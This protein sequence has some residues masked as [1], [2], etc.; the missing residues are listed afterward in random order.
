M[1]N[2]SDIVNVN[3][4]LEDPLV[5]STSFDHMLI[6]G[7]EPKSWAKLTDEEREAKESVYICSGVSEISEAD[8]LGALTDEINGDPIGIAG[9]VAFSQ[10]PKPDKVYFAVNKKLPATITE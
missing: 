1:K 8:A 5:D 7:P 3:I 2:L 10:E 6:I 4:S 9:R